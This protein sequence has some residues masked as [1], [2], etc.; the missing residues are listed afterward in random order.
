MPSA[1]GVLEGG[2]AKRGLRVY[3]RTMIQKHRHRIR[4]SVFSRIMECAQA[5]AVPPKLNHRLP[6][7]MGLDF[8]NLPTEVVERLAMVPLDASI[9]GQSRLGRPKTYLFWIQ[10][11]PVSL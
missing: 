9:V 8:L 7:L 6:A 11:A 2:F 5:I 1:D 10:R 3:I 4:V